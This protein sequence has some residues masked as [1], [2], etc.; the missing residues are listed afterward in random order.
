MPISYIFNN[1]SVEKRPCPAK[2]GSD[3]RFK[4]GPI[5]KKIEELSP[6]PAKYTAPSPVTSAPKKISTFG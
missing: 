6:G 1:S 3:I 4:Y 2:F 5:S